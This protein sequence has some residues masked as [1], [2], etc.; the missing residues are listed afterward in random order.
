MPDSA[1]RCVAQTICWIYAIDDFIDKN[2]VDATGQLRAPDTSQDVRDHWNDATL[3]QALHAIFAPL[4]AL[5]PG[6]IRRAPWAHALPTASG[7]AVEALRGSISALFAELGREWSLLPGSWGRGRYRVQVAA[8]Q[9]IAC[10]AMMCVERRWSV[11]AVV[12]PL[13]ATLPTSTR[14][15][16]VGAVSIGMPA[17]ASVVGGYEEHPQRRWR[18]A[19]KATMAAGRI[20]R[21]TNDLHTYEADVEEGKVSAVT[22]RLRD[23]GAPPFGHDPHTSEEVRRARAWVS[24]DLAHAI[25]D[26]SRHQQVLRS[27]ALSYYLRHSVAF[28]LAVY[29]DGSRMANRALTEP[30]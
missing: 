6:A 17:V 1:A 21:L 3:K 22:V 13:P 5:A 26:F 9:M 23:L 28:A 2:P 19:R 14:Y 11:A 24:E 25:A 16:E 4:V 10:V 18:S 20:V 29:G 7:P 8:E 12:S 15:L 27:G 30:A